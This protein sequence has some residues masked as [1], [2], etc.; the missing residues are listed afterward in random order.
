[1]TDSLRS[2]PSLP[3]TEYLGANS[4]INSIGSLDLLSRMLS[5]RKSSSNSAQLRLAGTVKGLGATKQAYV[6]IVAEFKQNVI[7]VALLR[8]HSETR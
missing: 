2:N 6:A 3:F 5:T 4:N 8:P 7:A 1:M